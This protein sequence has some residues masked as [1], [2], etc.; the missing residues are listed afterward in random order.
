[1]LIHIVCW[2]YKQES[3]THDR[4]RHRRMLKA[5]SGIIGPGES[6]DVGEDVLHLERSFDTGLFIRFTDRNALDRYT[7]HPEH[8]EAAA[9]GREVSEHVVSVDFFTDRPV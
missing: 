4:E 7:D 1:M 9:F 8:L 5:L 2:K 3:T 6:L